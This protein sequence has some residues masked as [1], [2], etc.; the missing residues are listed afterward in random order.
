MEFNLFAGLD[1]GERLVAVRA[2][3]GVW[4]EFG[5][6]ILGNA[7]VDL[8]RFQRRCQIIGETPDKL[9]DGF[10]FTLP[11]GFRDVGYDAL[12]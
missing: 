8:N 1:A 7:E 3:G 4:L 11:Q 9:S 6:N 10:Q 5:Q 12:S 2:F